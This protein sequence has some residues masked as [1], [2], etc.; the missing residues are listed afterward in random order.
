[1]PNGYDVIFTSDSGCTAKLNHEVETYHP[2]TGAV[3][4]WVK[5]PTV[6]H[7]YDTVIYLCYGNSS[8]TTDQSNKTGVWDSNFKGVWHLPNGSSLSANDSTSNANNGSISGAVAAAAKVGGGGDFN[9]SSNY[10]DVK[11]GK[12]DSSTTTGTVS[13]WVRISA[14]DTNG[15][16]LG[17]GGA[18]ATAP[19]MW[20][21][22]VR[23]VSSNRYFAVSGR[24]TAGATFNTVRGSTVLAANTWYY[25]TY[26]SNGSTWKIR[27]NGATAETL[28]AVLGTNSGQWIGDIT[29]TTPDKSVMGG[30]YAGGGYS[31]ANFWHGLLD[32]VRLS[33][34]ERSDDWVAT[35]YN[36]Q[37]SPA[38]FYTIS[39]ATSAYPPTVAIASP[40][41]G[42]VLPAPASI[43]ITANAADQDGTVSKV[44]FFKD[45]VKIGEDTSSPFSFAWNNVPSGSY[46]LTAVSTDNANATGTSAPVSIVVNSAPTVSITSPANNATLPAT[47]R[48]SFHLMRNTTFSLGKPF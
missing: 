14:L 9:G 24:A 3:N 20:G 47:T 25:V 15:A 40:A 21:V 22:Y 4:Y 45:N 38:T 33:N 48:M 23:E 8:I 6:S 43:T 7:T 10:I 31:S 13:A 11:A 17:Y 2:T 32:E 39:A 27:L 37:S 34:I 42:A 29:P 28:T 35:E 12:V 5:V 44:E 26:S 46:S 1:M 41:A 30:V 18:A 16:V 36:N 19:P